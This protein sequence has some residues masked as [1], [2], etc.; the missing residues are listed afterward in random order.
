MIRKLATV[1]KVPSFQC[2][3][4]VFTDDGNDAYAYV[5]PMCFQLGLIDYGQLI[6]IKD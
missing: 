3:L 5:L 1:L 4:E 2:P 6:K